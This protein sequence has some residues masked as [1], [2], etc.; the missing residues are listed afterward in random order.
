M[1]SGNINPTF[2]L[3]FRLPF[4]LIFGST[5][6]REI[7]IFAHFT[8]FVLAILWFAISEFIANSTIAFITSS[9]DVSNALLAWC[10]A[11]LSTK[12]FSCSLHCT[13]AKTSL[14]PT[15]KSLF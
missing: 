13:G 12:P 10:L 11:S 3:S 14:F 4:K 8:L 1:S 2:E 5:N 9:E 7:L 6:A 15:E